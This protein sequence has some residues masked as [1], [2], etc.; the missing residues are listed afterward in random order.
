MQR[1]ELDELHYITG[2]DNVASI[3]TLG[4]LSHSRAEAVPHRSVAMQEIQDIRA[5]KSIPGGGQLHHYVNLY[6]NGRNVMMSKVLHSEPIDA[7]CLLR[8]SVDVIDLPGVVIADQNAASD[9]VRFAP[10]AQALER[11]DRDTVF[12]TS[13]KHPDDQIAEWRHKSAMCAEVLVPDSVA[14]LHVL[15]AYV[16]SAGALANLAS[17]VPLLAAT[18]DPHKFLR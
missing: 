7:I 15:G 16:G 18:I 17:A 5:G 8:V 2:I 14:S 11:I 3:M 4:L 9:Y 10:P 13:W 12:A 6:I 1:R